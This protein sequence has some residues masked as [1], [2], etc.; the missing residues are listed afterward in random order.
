L[1][2][3]R[4]RAAVA[5]TSDPALLRGLLDGTAVPEGLTLDTELRWHVLRR[6]AALG[7]LTEDDIAVELSRDRSASGQL[8]A[9]A[10]LASLPG[11]DVKE[12]SWQALSGGRTTNAQ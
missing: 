8:Q 3:V 2:L 11:P 12:R 6:T 5:A 4:V 7:A 1:Q 9:E 10:A